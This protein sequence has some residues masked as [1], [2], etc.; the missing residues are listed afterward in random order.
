MNIKYDLELNLFD[1]VVT[2]LRIRFPE[3]RYKQLQVM[4]CVFLYPNYLEAI[5]EKNLSMNKQ[6]SRQLIQTLY[7]EEY[8]ENRTNEDG[9]KGKKVL[10]ADIAKSLQLT[11]YQLTVNVKIK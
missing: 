8:L 9:T 11:D 6:S 1:A 10:R 7:D 5:M 2:Q 4:A 3:A